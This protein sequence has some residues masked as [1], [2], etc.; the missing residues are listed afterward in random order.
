MS[1]TTRSAVSRSELVA[2]APQARINRIRFS[3]RCSQWK[4]GARCRG[5]SRLAGSW[6]CVEASPA[7]GTTAQ[8][9][10]PP[11]HPANCTALHLQCYCASPPAGR[12]ETARTGGWGRPGPPTA[13]AAAPGPHRSPAQSQTSHGTQNIIG[14]DVFTTKKY[15]CL[16]GWAAP[17][18]RT[19]RQEERLSSVSL[20]NRLHTNI[21]LCYS[22]WWPTCTA[23][24][25]TAG[26]S[27]RTPAG[28][29]RVQPAERRELEL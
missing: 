20:T 24:S 7:G 11:A 19:R 18:T 27:G 15:L 4:R 16:A 21:C 3:S 23:G 14:R 13:P 17:E 9:R 22:D 12:A 29:Y 10:P 1:V 6:C 26:C 28:E 2:A 8:T 5:P 25:R